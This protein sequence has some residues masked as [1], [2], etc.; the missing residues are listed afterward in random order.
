MKLRMM[1]VVEKNSVE[2]ARYMGNWIGKLSGPK[3][4]NS[5]AMPPK[6]IPTFSTENIARKGFFYA[7]GSYWGEPGSG[8][9]RARWVTRSSTNLFRRRS[10]SPAPPGSSRCR[11]VSPC[12][13]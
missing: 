11:Q 12:W 10:S 3:P 2:I 1:T 8:R 4:A 13:T 7:G 5:K 6:T 9:A